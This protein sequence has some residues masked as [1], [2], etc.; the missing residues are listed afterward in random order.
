MGLQTDK[1]L[2]DI[3]NNT[4]EASSVS[5]IDAAGLRKCLADDIAAS[6]GSRH[7]FATD[8]CINDSHLSEFLNGTKNFGRD[9]LLCM[10]LTLRYDFEKIQSML[11]R[12]GEAPLYVRNK[13]DYQIAIA[14]RG[15]KTLDETDQL[16]MSAHLKTLT[17]IDNF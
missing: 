2:D 15:G 4:S 8:C 17:S 3:K 11:T 1:I 13:R 10:F 14:V 9:K 16:L 5:F 7:K 12:F 6:Y